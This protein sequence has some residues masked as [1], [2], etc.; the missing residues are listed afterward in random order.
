MST[1]QRN[2]LCRYHYDPLDRLADCTP[3]AQARI[4][5]FYLKE[6]LTS[7]I[8]DSV[9]RSIFQQ[10]DYLLAQQQRQSGAVETTLLATNLQR[11]VLHALSAMQSHA[12]VYT[13]YGHRSPESGLLSLLGFNGERPDL[14]TGHYLLG[15]GYRAFNPLLMGFNSPDS[16]SPFAEGGLNAYAYCMGDPVNNTDPTGHLPNLW[17]GLLNVLGIRT[18]RARVAATPSQATAVD[19]ANAA[20]PQ[21]IPIA[22]P[23]YSV[24][25]YSGPVFPPPS[26]PPPAYRASPPQYAAHGSDRLAPP[27]IVL[28]EFVAS[29]QDA[30]PPFRGN[31]APRRPFGT[32]HIVRAPSGRGSSSSS[33][34]RPA[35][36]GRGP[37]HPVERVIQQRT[38]QVRQ[39]RQRH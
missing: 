16:W 37:S 19:A 28:D 24:G 22:P 21:S 5:R 25:D 8:Q 31:R 30:P 26:G 29:A 12:L 23:P 1:S 2:V 15:N 32:Q 38:A 20:A 7:E 13:P 14:V 35:S 17:K 11:T 33:S 10:D 3:S 27:L 4:Q 6:R 39:G 9:Q 36:Q 34:S 18:F